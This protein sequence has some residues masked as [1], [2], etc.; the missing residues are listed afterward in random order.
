MSFAFA[1]AGRKRKLKLIVWFIVL[2]VAK[3]N[4][5]INASRNQHRCH[6]ISEATGN[7]RRVWSAVNN[8]LHGDRGA[9]DELQ[10]KNQ[11]AFVQ[12]LANYFINKVRNIQVSITTALG[13]CTPAPM[14]AD[15]I[16]EG[17]S[18]TTFLTVTPFEVK[19]LIQSMPCK[20]SP[21]DFIPTSLIKSCSSVFSVIISHLA[22][23]SFSQGYFPSKF[24][25]AQITPLLKR[26]DFDG[27]Y[28]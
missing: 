21:L 7:H 23:L 9:V 19:R 17:E 4:Q 1:G 25:K 20:S 13:G 12:T 6:Q 5:L 28:P 8:L 16:H 24:K 27:K 14:N 18:L 3:A 22:N 10:N 11:A 15:K 2:P 26:Q